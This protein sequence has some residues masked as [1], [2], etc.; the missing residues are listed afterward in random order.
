MTNTNYPWSDHT[1]VTLKIQANININ[2][3]FKKQRDWNKFRNIMS[4]Y[5]FFNKNIKNSDD[6]DNAIDDL[7]KNIQ[8]TLQISTTTF[9]FQENSNKNTTPEK[10]KLILLKRRARNTWQT[11][12]QVDNYFLNNLKSTFKNYNN[13]LYTTHL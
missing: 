4:T 6:I 11:D 12:T 5:L 9:L 1:P 3:I 2:P 13:H 10:K 8:A 7:K